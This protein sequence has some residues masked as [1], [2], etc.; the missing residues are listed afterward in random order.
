M[1]GLCSEQGRLGS[2]LAGPP[3]RKPLGG[4]LRKQD[5]FQA[6]GKSDEV[7]ILPSPARW[8]PGLPGGSPDLLP[9]SYPRRQLS[10]TATVRDLLSTKKY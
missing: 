9:A 10:D 4:Q 2:A 8:T 6:R 5:E 7:V 1:E 3:G